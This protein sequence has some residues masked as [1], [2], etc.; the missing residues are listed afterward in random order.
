M[1]SHQHELHA[2][3]YLPASTDSALMWDTVESACSTEGVP[4]CCFALRSSQRKSLRFWFLFLFCFFLKK[5]KP[6]THLQQLNQQIFPLHPTGEGFK[7]TNRLKTTQHI[8][9]LFDPLETAQKKENLFCYFVLLQRTLS[10]KANPL[11]AVFDHVVTKYSL[12]HLAHCKH[13]LQ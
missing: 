13:T 2:P 10:A 5:K 8:Q 7:V 9:E 6:I 3:C 12:F 1:T 4:K 11:P